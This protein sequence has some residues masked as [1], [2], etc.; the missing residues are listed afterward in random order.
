MFRQVKITRYAVFRCLWRI[1]INIPPVF[2]GVFCYYCLL[3]A[4]LPVIKNTSRFIVYCYE[5]RDNVLVS[6]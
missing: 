6:G 3:S 1:Y 2:A 4:P 5:S